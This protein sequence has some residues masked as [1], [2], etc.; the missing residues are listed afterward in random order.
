MG[1][2]PTDRAV[3]EGGPSPSSKLSSGLYL[4]PPLEHHH[5]KLHWGCGVPPLGVQ[6]G[7]EA[8]REGRFMAQMPPAPLSGPLGT[9]LL[10]LWKTGVQ[11][12][13]WV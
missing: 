2:T 6:P 10:G 3:L 12:L 11:A 13:T 1:V 5:L 4:R 7:S 8:M 9:A